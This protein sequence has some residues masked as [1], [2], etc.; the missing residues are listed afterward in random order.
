MTASG[1]SPS[2]TPFMRAADA[3][4]ERVV[5]ILQ[6]AFAEGRITVD[7]FHERSDQAYAAKTLGDLRP[8]TADLPAQDLARPGT[9]MDPTPP[10]GDGHRFG[11]GSWSPVVGPGRTSIQRR[12]ELKAIWATW[13]SVTTITMV[14]WI[15]SCI[16]TTSLIPFWPIFPIG[17][18]GA[19]AALRTFGINNHDHGRQHGHQQGP[20]RQRNR[21]H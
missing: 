8:L 2:P 1:A 18:L 10:A 15:A 6:E 21:D 16:V 3:D 13:I 9:A 11:S 12:R 17:F 4:R 19:G 14:I 7:E 20:D 5:S